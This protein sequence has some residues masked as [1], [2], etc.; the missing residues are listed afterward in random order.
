MNITYRTDKNILYIAIEGRIDASNAAV[1]EEKIFN[2]KKENEGKVYDQATGL[3]LTKDQEKAL[4]KLAQL[5]PRS[6]RTTAFKEAY[7]T[8]KDVMKGYYDTISQD[9]R[10]ENKKGRSGS[11]F[12]EI[13][14]LE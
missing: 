7:E 11:W 1:A 6:V 8:V 5:G 3:L 14:Y 13:W 2:I 10:K 12:Y 4:K 9:Q